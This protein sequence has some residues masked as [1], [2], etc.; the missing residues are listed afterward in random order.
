MQ[1]SQQNYECRA[2]LTNH[3]TSVKARTGTH[4]RYI[5]QK[6]VILLK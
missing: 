4:L 6:I 5:F 2:P 3:L 1:H